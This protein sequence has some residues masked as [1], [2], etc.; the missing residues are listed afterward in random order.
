LGAVDLET[1]GQHKFKFASL[2]GNFGQNFLKKHH[3]P[4]EDFDTVY[5]IKNEKHYSKLSAIAEIG[6][7]LG[8]VYY[9]F[10]LAHLLPDIISNPIYNLIAENRKKI[11]G[12]SCMLITPEERKQFLS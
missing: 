8:G 2:Q 5:F 10:A 11:A 3:L 1:G 4:T 6:K 9:F 7:T 12:E